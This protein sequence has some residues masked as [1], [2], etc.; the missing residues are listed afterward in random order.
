[1][2][3]LLTHFFVDLKSEIPNRLKKIKTQRSKIA[4]RKLNKK[5]A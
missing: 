5:K 1:L 3:V 4:Y 2:I